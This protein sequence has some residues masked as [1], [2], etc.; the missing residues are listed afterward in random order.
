MCECMKICDEGV[1]TSSACLDSIVVCVHLYVLCVWLETV[2]VCVCTLQLSCA[3]DMWLIR[4]HRCVFEMGS[5]IHSHPIAYIFNSS[6]R[7][8]QRGRAQSEGEEEGEGVKAKKIP[9]EWFGSDR[10]RRVSKEK[11]G[12]GE[13]LNVNSQLISQRISISESGIC[14]NM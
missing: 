10:K 2:C 4:C 3:S 12:D 9:K 7:E 1:C 11:S 6:P 8:R 14:L 5:F 13:K